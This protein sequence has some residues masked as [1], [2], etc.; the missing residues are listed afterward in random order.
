LSACGSLSIENLDAYQRDGF[1]VL[2]EFI[3]RNRVAEMA[4]AIENI[5]AH[6]S[7]LPL[8]LRKKLVLE[9]DLP[10]KRRG[11]IPSQAA[12]DAIF[13][14]GDLPAF[15]VRFAT[16]LVE[17]S[18][19]QL[20]QALLGT[21]EI[22]YH[23]SNVTMKRERVGSGISWHRD[24]PNQYI[25]PANSSFL[26]LMICLDGMDIENGATQFIQGS[27]QL[28]DIEA[29]QADSKEEADKA[30]GMIQTAI[31]L[32]GSL[33]FISPK[34]LHGGPPNTSN[35]HRRNVIVQWGRTDDPITPKAEES[36]CGMTAAEI[37]RH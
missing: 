17:P 35:R 9:R 4:A 30:D 33:V 13:I 15:D 23:F 27:H 3:S 18:L 10:A 12:G 26:R 21:E 22:C 1:I 14:I 37:R 24:F 25:C 28:T 19:I 5:Q 8:E 7:E 29:R 11:G 32:P 20:V 31:C 34:S 2:P 6:H 16:W 36:L